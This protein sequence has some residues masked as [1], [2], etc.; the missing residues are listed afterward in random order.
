MADLTEIH[1]KRI[2]LRDL[3]KQLKNPDLGLFERCELQDK[4]LEIKEVLGEFERSHNEG[5]GCVNCSG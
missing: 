4:I 2:Q 1:A 5:E 3:E